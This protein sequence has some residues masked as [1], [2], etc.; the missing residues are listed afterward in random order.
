[1]RLPSAIR[2]GGEQSAADH[3]HVRAYGGWPSL[4]WPS[5]VC[6]VCPLVLM[7]WLFPRSRPSF[8]G[9]RWD[10]CKPVCPA[11]LEAARIQED[12]QQV[13]NGSRRRRRMARAVR[14]QPRPGAS[15][16]SLREQHARVPRHLGEDAGAVALHAH[17][18]AVR[19]PGRGAGD[20]Q[21]A[22]RVG[23]RGVPGRGDARVVQR[24]AR[25]PPGAPGR[26]GPRH[27]RRDERAAAQGARQRPHAHALGR[28][29]Q[30]GLHPRGGQA[31]DAR[32]RRLPQV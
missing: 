30:C 26:A 19:V 6:A 10:G 31:V 3:V 23:H 14:Q 25:A 1:M 27:E 5:A 18:D 7:K 13:S 11:R 21:R 8:T 24:G 22:S 28:H 9:H 4:A 32:Q 2:Q 29:G 15:A 17:G 16:G 20:G 12:H